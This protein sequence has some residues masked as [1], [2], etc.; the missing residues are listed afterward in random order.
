MPRILIGSPLNHEALPLLQWIEVAS[1]LQIPSFHIVG[2]PSQEVS[3]SRERIRAAI[4]NSGFEFPRRRIVLNL[5]P[6]NIPKRGTGLD[7]AM[8]LSILTG[9]D[10]VANPAEAKDPVRVIASGELGLDGSVKATGQVMRALYACWASGAPA[11]VLAM[12]EKQDALDKFAVLK[13]SLLFEAP[14]PDLFFVSTLQ[15][16]WDVVQGISRGE[17]SADTHNARDSGPGFEDANAPPEEALRLMPLSASLERTLGAAAAGRHHILLLGPRG[18]GKTYALE[19]LIA[20]QPEA[21]PGVRIHQTLLAELNSPDAGL[22]RRI[23]IRRIGMQVRPAALTGCVRSTGIRPGEF[24]LAHGGLLIADELPEW[25]RDARES[26]RE[27]LERKV[28]TLTRAAAGS[29]EL[30]ADFVFAANGNFCPCGGWPPEIPVPHGLASRSR[31]DLRCRCQDR[32]RQ[33]YLAKL[34]GPVLDRVDVLVRVSTPPL[35]ETATGHEVNRLRDKVARAKQIA[36]S[37]WGKV[38]GDLS[39]QELEDLMKAHSD[40]ARNLSQVGY[41]SL[42]S[43]HKIL[44]LALTLSCW[45]ELDEPGLAHFVEASCYRPEKQGF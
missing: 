13:E 45:D 4:E 7:L 8:A 6:A 44:R 34:S 19:W 23:P 21:T 36:L 39:S 9:S 41:G 24:A 31:Q 42:R 3:E 27:P 26:L 2:L 10:E 38:A 40:W 11:L 30:P 18:T 20:L 37:R 22:S 28:S 25:P 17:L 1:S 15:E 14:A 35:A 29:I 5:S 16:A 33:S 32:M 12:R 43:R